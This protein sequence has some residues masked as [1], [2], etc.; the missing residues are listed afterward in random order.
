MARNGLVKTE[1]ISPS[2]WG[3]RRV[4]VELPPVYLEDK[5][6]LSFTIPEYGKIE[7]IFIV[8]DHLHMVDTGKGYV[9]RISIEP[10][11]P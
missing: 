11:E 8:E 5:I 4:Q 9:Q 6:Y 7:G 1:L 2:V 10:F 3:R